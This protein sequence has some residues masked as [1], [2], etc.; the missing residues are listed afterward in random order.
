MA[1][2]YDAIAAAGGISKGPLRYETAKARRAE[3][4]ATERTVNTDVDHR[5]NHRCRVCGRWCNPD[6]VTLLERA[7]RHHL[8]YRSR[9]GEDTT[10][11]KA[12]LC[13]DCHAD[14]H[15]GKLK[16]SG[17]ADLRD[18]ITRTLCGIKVERPCEAGWE[19]TAWV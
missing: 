13:P 19:I 11:N 3:K 5:D 2:D 6:A 1:I 15:G 16:L 7:H 10:A 9:G 17:D 14:E 8:L 12:T 18:P 4:Q